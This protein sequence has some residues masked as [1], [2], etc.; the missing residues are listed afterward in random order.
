MTKGYVL[1]VCPKSL[2][3]DTSTDIKPIIQGLSI[4][5]LCPLPF[6]LWAASGVI[7]RPLHPPPNVSSLSELFVEEKYITAPKDE[8]KVERVGPY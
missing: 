8:T 4:Y 3:E 6:N 7:K 2:H 5:G 1:E